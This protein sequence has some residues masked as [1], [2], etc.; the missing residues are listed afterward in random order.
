MPVLRG[1]A[2]AA[3]LMLPAALSGQKEAWLP[4][5]P[6]DLAVQEVPDN[7]GAPAIQL[8]Y[9]QYINDN[10]V[11]NEGEYIYRRIKILNDRGN[12]Y[13]DVEIRLPSDFALADL[14]AR[15][16]HPDG[17]IIDFTGKPFDKVIAKGKGFKYLAKTFT[18]PD[19]TV[20]SILEYRYKLNYPAGVLPAH[21]WI[22][23]HDLYTVKEDF[24]IES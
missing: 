1:F 23:Q 11:N 10:D 12:K 18:L 13:A 17:K 20:G 5:T 6:Q 16:I 4:V 3:C 21:E 14:K 9:S 8:Y 15:T 2:L 19:V 7:P 24:H 22:A